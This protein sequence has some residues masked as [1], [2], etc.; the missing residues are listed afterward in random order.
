MVGFEQYLIKYIY[1]SMCTSTS[2]KAYS[3]FHSNKS[4]PLHMAYSVQPIYA[5]PPESYTE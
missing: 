1:N 5:S 3:D 2:L 4:M